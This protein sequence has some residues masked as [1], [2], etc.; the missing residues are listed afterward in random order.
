MA[1]SSSILR[2]ILFRYA[3]TTGSAAIQAKN[4]GVAASGFV[5]PLAFW[6]IEDY[7]F[8]YKTHQS[9]AT[10][11]N[12]VMWSTT[13]VLIAMGLGCYCLEQDK[14]DDSKVSTLKHETL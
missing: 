6:L 11:F 9:K 14:P 4:T 10:A 3:T 5:I 12:I 8:D 1:H 13:W 2:I 7:L